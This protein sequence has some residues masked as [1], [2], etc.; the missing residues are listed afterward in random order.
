MIIPSCVQLRNVN[1]FRGVLEAVA[2]A[3]N[4]GIE[5]IRQKTYQNPIDIAEGC[6]ATIRFDQSLNRIILSGQ[7]DLS[8]AATSA[9]ARR[10]S[11]F[12]RRVNDT[13]ATLFRSNCFD[14][15]KT[16]K[17]AEAR[18]RARLKAFIKR[19]LVQMESDLNDLS[20]GVNYYCD[21]HLS[22]FCC[23]GCA[24]VLDSETGRAYALFDRNP[25]KGARDYLS[26]VG[27]S[28]GG[29]NQLWYMDT[30][31]DPNRFTEMVQGFCVGISAAYHAEALAANRKVRAISSATAAL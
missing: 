30:T 3:N 17:N 8:A 15:Y 14:V 27:F 11:A 22:I 26:T 20:E 6:I 24:L 2:D 25:C 29:T 19:W 12:T 7:Q 31:V 16:S 28:R 1:S 21:G 10:T 5:V 13:A 23:A 18:Q 4:A 9:G